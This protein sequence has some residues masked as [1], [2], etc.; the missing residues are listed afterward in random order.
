M[1]FSTIVQQ[2]IRFYVYLLVDK[3]TKDLIYIGKGQKNR[4]FDHVNDAYKNPNSVS[5]KYNAIRKAGKNNID[6]YIIAHDLDEK[7]ALIVERVLLDFVACNNITNYKNLA[8]I[9][10]GH[11]HA[12]YGIQKTSEIENLYGC[13]TLKIK[14]ADK[15]MLI[16]INN[17]YMTPHHPTIY[18]AVRTCWRINVNRAKKANYV[19][20]VYRGVTV[21][22]FKDMQWSPV[23]TSKGNTRWE[24]TATEVVNSQ[25]KN[26]RIGDTIKFGNQNPIR[27]INL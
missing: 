4:V 13:P 27:Y 21:G 16:S 10:N 14:L 11:G 12:L 19:I 23:K 20:A 5:L 7:T 15:V 9:Q 22:V 1:G 26:K 3:R 17:S 8:N 25:Y 18:D 2:S 24:F 6:Y